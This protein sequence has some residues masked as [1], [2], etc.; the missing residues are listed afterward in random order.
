MQHLGSITA[1]FAIL[2]GIGG[3]EHGIEGFSDFVEFT[4]NLKRYFCELGNY[5]LEGKEVENLIDLIIDNG[6]YIDPTLVL[7]DARTSDFV[8]LVDDLNFFL[9]DSTENYVVRMRN[10]KSRF[11]DQQ[12]I[13]KLMENSVEFVRRIYERGGTIVTGTDPVSIEIL[14]GYG[15][16]REIEILINE[17]GVPLVEAIKMA[18]LN[19][20]QILGIEDDHGSIEK[21]KIANLSIMDGNVVNDLKALYRTEIVLKNGEIYKTSELLKSVEN[22]ISFGNWTP[23]DKE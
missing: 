19:G 14:P 11:Y 12:C 6:V 4:G 16:K 7:C 1:R 17:V 3:L 9:N 10:L 23:N 18:S 13:K 8:P 5:S 2:N 20:S 22:K 21:G 15:I